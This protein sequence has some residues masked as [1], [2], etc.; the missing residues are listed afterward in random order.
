MRDWLS[1]LLLAELYERRQR[2]TI[3]KPGCKQVREAVT[4]GDLVA[5]VEYLIAA[6]DPGD[7]P[8][9]AWLGEPLE[10]AVEKWHEDGR[11]SSTQ[12]TDIQENLAEGK[13]TAAVAA[14]EA[15]AAEAR[16]GP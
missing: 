2:D 13:W 4:A 6:T 1:H 8:V 7:Q 9:A 16:K 3:S 5:G 15:A 10:V 14:I 11:L 12:A